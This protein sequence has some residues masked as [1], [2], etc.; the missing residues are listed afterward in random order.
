MCAGSHL[1]WYSVAIAWASALSGTGYEA[2]DL[3][4]AVLTLTSGILVW[5]WCFQARKALQQYAADEYGFKLKMNVIY[6]LLFSLYY[7]NYCINDFETAK[8]IN[9][10]NM[11]AM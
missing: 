8:K 2:V 5:V 4:S 10:T 1:I 11:V 3:V 7:I 6:T 9:S